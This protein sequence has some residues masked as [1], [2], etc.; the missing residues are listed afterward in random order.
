[1][2][3]IDFLYASARR[4]P[5]II[6]VDAPGAK[7]TYAQLVAR[8]DA[9]AAGLQDIDAAPQ[10]RVGICAHNTLD[11]LL[12]L[13]ATLAAGKTWVP[14]NP[15]EVKAELDAKIA[16]TR[17]SIIIADEDCLDHFSRPNEATLVVGTTKLAREGKRPERANLP[18]DA[19]QAIKFTGGTTS[20]PKGVM[21]PYRAW[22]TG[23]VCMIHGFGFTPD[24]RVLLAAPL[25]HGT[26]CYVAP[27]LALGATLVLGAARA[28][29]SDVLD[30]FAER[31]VT[32]TFLPPTMIY[33]MMAEPGVRER[34]YPRLSKLIYGAAS[35][36]PPKIREAETVFGKVLATNYGQTEAPQVITTLAPED[37][38]D[39]SNLASVGRASLLTRVAVMDK[40]GRILPP[41]E[42]GEIVV[43]GDLLMT[44][45]LDMPEQ[46]SETIVDGWLH[47][48][49]GGIVDERGF[50]CLRD[51]LRDVIITGGFNVYPSD[52]EAA[53]VRHPKVHECV[54][55]GLA[56]DKWGE[57]VNAAVQLK[58]GARASEEELV[59]FAKQELGS[60]KAPKRVVF[61]DDLPRSAVGKVLRREVKAMEERKI[62]RSP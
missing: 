32:A 3:P 30:A 39:D 54:V 1:M 43:A 44:G 21:Q 15:R 11:H 26:S 16:A 47:T 13:L 42:D 36:P 20:R 60:V 12:A 38:R 55:F 22:T 40:S 17:P 2:F 14:L 62:D 5:D 37:F 8:V 56:D 33:M 58:S 25:T 9:L 46:T 28:R 7:L 52:V 51:R 29:P 31:D 48:G 57:A 50:V 18:L 49:D 27:T 6:A 24:E 34:K 35:M 61:Y 59:A 45:Y 19:T 53:L 4:R 41:G 10:S 23:A